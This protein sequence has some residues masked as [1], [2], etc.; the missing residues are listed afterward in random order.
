MHY[1]GHRFW[2]VLCRRLSI[3]LRFL[4][5]IRSGSFVCVSAFT[6]IEE[7]SLIHLL[8]YTLS[9]IISLVEVEI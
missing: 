5:R 3:T 7:N 9:K 4:Q 1:R 8:T 6:G 2:V